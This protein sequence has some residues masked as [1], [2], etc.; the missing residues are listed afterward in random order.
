VLEQKPEEA[1][2]IADE[3]LTATEE[4]GSGATL[5]ALLHRVRGY[6]LALTLEAIARLRGGEIA[7]AE[8]RGL[9]ARLGVVSTPEIPV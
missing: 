5:R 9:L 8:S 7:A 3:V 4:S 2:A 6:E 1:L